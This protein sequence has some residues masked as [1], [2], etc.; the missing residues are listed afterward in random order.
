MDKTAQGFSVRTPSTPQPK[1][2]KERSP[3]KKD[4]LWVDTI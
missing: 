3:A 4:H 2:R 1:T